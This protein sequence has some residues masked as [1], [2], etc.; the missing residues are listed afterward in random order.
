MQME[1]RGG[2]A[3]SN[4]MMNTQGLLGAGQRLSCFD[5]IHIRSSV[6]P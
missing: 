5:E 3:E 1:D 6:A 4:T 2:Q